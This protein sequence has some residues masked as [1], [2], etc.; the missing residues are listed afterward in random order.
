MDKAKI[1][2]DNFQPIKDGGS[3][4]LQ[5]FAPKNIGNIN[6]L[7]P[8]YKPSLFI[9]SDD[10]GFSNLL[11]LVSLIK[12]NLE[13]QSD[14]FMNI[15]GADS[16]YIYHLNRTKS[17]AGGQM[18]DNGAG[19]LKTDLATTERETLLFTRGDDL[20]AAYY[21]T[22]DSGT[23]TSITLKD[24]EGNAVST[25]YATYGINNTTSTK[26]I[27]NLTK[28]E[29]Y[30][31]TTSTPTDTLNFT[32]ATTTPETGDEVLI[33]LSEKFLFFAN[34]AVNKHFIGQE[35]S[36]IWIR[37]IVN[38]GNDYYITN[39][40]YLAVL[41]SDETT[42]AKEEKQLPHSTQA[43][44][45]ASNSDKI[46]VGGDHKGSGKL[47]L[48]DGESSFWNYSL[49]MP[50]APESIISYGGD[51]LVM[52][53]GVLYWTNGYEMNKIVELPD[54]SFDNS[55]C[56]YNGLKILNDKVY[57]V[58]NGNSYIRTKIGLYIYDLKTKGFSFC[59]FVDGYSSYPT[60]TGSAGALILEPGQTE[61]FCGTSWGFTKI[62]FVESSTYGMNS[63]Y[64]QFLIDLPKK[65]K[66]NLIELN[67]SLT[68]N[69]IDNNPDLQTD[70]IV[71]IGD[72]R[73]GF[74]YLL[75]L[76]T[77]STTT[78]LVSTNELNYD[79]H[80]EVDEQIEIIQNNTNSAGEKRFITV[81]ADPQTAT[82]D[83]TIDQAINTA[84]TS[85]TGLLHKLKKQGSRNIQ[86]Q[87]LDTL[88]DLTYPIKD[89]YS[90]KL[91]LE[92][93][94]RKVTDKT[95]LALNINSINIY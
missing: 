22:V 58:N 4:F 12:T 40:N 53:A 89:F 92:V 17:S 28:G 82:V 18:F 33:F 1:T 70:V 94:F 29:G 75:D 57:I 66:L 90:D 88:T 55:S 36:N 16:R 13:C 93:L 8:T 38:F 6:I 35:N 47:L 32:T 62:D 76:G 25:L 65:M 79:A 86:V 78:K 83:Y 56:S 48:W 67:L 69:R 46:L 45:I 41:E 52:S 74:S 51:F 34:S 68:N 26:H 95:A 44:C 9:D 49:D 73:K 37:Q 64:A 63:Y 72:G 84:P 61:L 81:I 7:C 87:D 24:Y 43:T 2:L 54:N 19:T 3:Y 11:T 80:A 71:S 14:T 42:F 77:G 85:A 39:G 20:G 5:G 15:Y 60:Y 91:W 30:D 21:F 23:S 31:N 27:F 59:P 50:F 10:T